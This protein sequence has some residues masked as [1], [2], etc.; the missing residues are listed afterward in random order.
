LRSSGRQGSAIADEMIAFGQDTNWQKAVLDYA[1]NY[2]K[3]VKKDYEEF[4]DAYEQK[5]FS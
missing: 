5:Y 3:Q 4:A 1:L 2:S